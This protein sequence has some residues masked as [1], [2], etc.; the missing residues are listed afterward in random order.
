MSLVLFRDTHL[1]KSVLYLISEGFKK[2]TRLPLSNNGFFDF[3]LTKG[4]THRL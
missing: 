1:S 4:K 3:M 2:A